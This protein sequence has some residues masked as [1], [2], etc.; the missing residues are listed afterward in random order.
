[1]ENNIRWGDEEV[2][3]SISWQREKEEE[4]E[5][6]TFFFPFRQFVSPLHG[7]GAQRCTENWYKTGPQPNMGPYRYLLP[8]TTYFKTKLHSTLHE[9]FPAR[10]RDSSLWARSRNFTYRYH[11]WWQR[12]V[13]IFIIG[14]VCVIQFHIVGHTCV[15]PNMGCLEYT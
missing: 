8:P 7:D 9:Q 1:M 3:V 4:R 13:M 2:V 5:R 10:H 11:I 14:H 12:L 6:A 15:S